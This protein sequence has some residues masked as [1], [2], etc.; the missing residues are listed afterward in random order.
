MTP[1]ADQKRNT[2]AQKWHF[3]QSL[4]RVDENLSFCLN[5]SARSSRVTSWL[6]AVEVLRGRWVN[7]STEREK[8][9]SN[10]QTW[11]VPGFRNSST[12]LFQLVVTSFYPLAQITAKVY[13]FVVET[14]RGN[15]GV[16]QCGNK[17]DSSSHT[18]L[19]TLSPWEP[20]YISSTPHCAGSVPPPPPSSPG[21]SLSKDCDKLQLGSASPGSSAVMLF[22]R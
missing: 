5:S 8:K 21:S 17:Q 18:C 9:K 2:R 1:K 11:E 15:S 3:E 7:N 16:Q 22:P 12:P 14:A 20:F 10:F 4:R 13:S 19:T 6:S